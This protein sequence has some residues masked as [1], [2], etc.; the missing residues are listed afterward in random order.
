MAAN[1]IISTQSWQK[2]RVKSYNYKVQIAHDELRRW[3]SQNLAE[4][5]LRGPG[6]MYKRPGM[7]SLV[8]NG[9]EDSIPDVVACGTGETF[10]LGSEHYTAE[11]WYL[12]YNFSTARSAYPSQGTSDLMP[13]AINLDWAF[14]IGVVLSLT[15]IVFTFDSISG[16]KE[17]GTL[18]LIMSNSVSRSTV[19]LGKALGAWITLM[20]PLILTILMNLVIVSL[21]GAEQ[22]LYLQSGDW[23]RIFIAIFISIVYGSIFLMLGFFV[24]SL[25]SRSATSIFTLLLIWVITVVLLPSALGTVAKKLRPLPLVEVIRQNKQAQIQ[26]I[27]EKHR[28]SEYSK[29]GVWPPEGSTEWLQKWA[30]YITEQAE[31]ETKFNNENVDDQIAQAELAMDICRASPAAVYQYA[32]ESIAGVGIPRYKDFI[33]QVRIHAQQF[34][35]F[36]KSTDRHDKESHHIYFVGAGMSQKPVDFDNVPKFEDKPKL[37]IAFK[38]AMFDITLLILQVIFLFMCAH[39]AFLRMDVK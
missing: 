15:A 2:E 11:M 25:T 5:G 16:E 6:R 12:V 33:R 10:D 8:A 7:L 20:I 4:L 30:A 22:Y 23:Y 35:D 18:A 14:L 36:I 38:S 26:S 19:L 13:K 27:R 28:V 37:D 3:S 17:R 21:I 24:S 9:N 32:L 29:E 31:E 1:G 39:V 34:V